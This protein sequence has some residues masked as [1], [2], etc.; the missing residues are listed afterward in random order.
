M[1]TQQNTF[2]PE[3][4]F[5]LGITGPNSMNSKGITVGNPEGNMGGMSGAFQGVIPGGDIDSVIPGLKTGGISF[6]TECGIDDELFKSIFG[7]GAMNANFF[8]VFDNGNLSIFGL[9]KS[10]SFAIKSL[11][12]F[13]SLQHLS[14]KSQTGSE[15]KGA[16]SVIGGGGQSQG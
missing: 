2:S 5:A 3:T 9:T 8:A 11:G 7:E 16:T 13:L 12:T 14:I 10:E 6:L 4:I 15:L 1:S